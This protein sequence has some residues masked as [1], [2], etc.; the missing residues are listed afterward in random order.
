M[1]QPPERGARKPIRTGGTGWRGVQ[2][3]LLV[4]GLLPPLAMRGNS[5][6]TADP[7]YL[8]RA[9]ET[10][11]GLPEN[12]ATAMAQTT[13]GYLWFGTFEGLVRFDGVRFA[14]F[15]PANL[16]ELPSAA[17]VNLHGDALGRLWVSTD[18]GLCRWS[19]GRWHT[20]SEQDGWVGDYVRSF[21]SRSNG[22]VLL[23]TFDGH[24][25]EYANGRLRALPPPPGE[26]GRG[27]FTHADE[28]GRWWVIQHAFAG[29]WDGEAWKPAVRLETTIPDAV[30]AGGGHDGSLWIV[31]GPRLRHWRR[32]KEE[33]SVPLPEPP[34]GIW[35]VLGDRAG[36]VWICTYNRGLCRVG[37]DGKFR[38]WDGTRGGVEDSTRFVLEDGEDNLWV[39]TSGGGLVQF[40][41]RRFQAFGAGSGRGE[42]NVKAV[43]P[44][45]SGGMW[46]ATFGGGLVRWRPGWQEAVALSGSLSRTIY[47]QAVIEDR[48]GTTWFGALHRG[49]WQITEEGTRRLDPGET[50]GESIRALYEDGKG[51][52]WVGGDANLALFETGL[53]RPLPQAFKRPLPGVVAIAEEGDLQLWFSN[54]KAVFRLKSDEV[55]EVLGPT[56]APLADV[57]CFKPVGDGSVWMGTR[58]TGLWQWKAGNLARVDRAAGFPAAGAHAILEDDAGYFWMPS[59]QGVVRASRAVLAAA[60]EGGNLRGKVQLLDTGDGLPSLDMSSSSQPVAAPDA[61]GR[62][63]FATLKGMAMIEPRRFRP[64]TNPPPV[65]IEA[66]HY[67][68]PGKPSEA[69][70]G[71]SKP[72][73]DGT[74]E[75]EHGLASPFPARLRLPAGSRRLEIH[76]TATTFAA[77]EK[78]RFQVKLEKVDQ[79]WRDA[80]ARRQALFDDLASGDYVFRVRAAN[81]DGVWNERG[82]SLA[83]TVLPHYWET[84]WFRLGTGLFL[85]GWGAAAV[86]MAARRRLQRAEE[87]ERTA[88]QMRELA[89]RLINAQEDERRRIAREL[90]DDFSQRLALLSVEMDLC[91]AGLGQ[92]SPDSAARFEEMASRV[93]E[94]SS[95]VHR[96]AYELHPAKLDQLGL[97]AAARGFCRDLSQQTGV[98]IRFEACPLPTQL[99]PRQ[100]LCLYR[101]IQESLWNVVRHSGAKDARVELTTDAGHVRLVVADSGAGFDPTRAEGGLGLA[102]MLERVRLVQGELAVESK[103]GGGTRILVRLPVPPAP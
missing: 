45:S 41:P 14:V 44:A 4:L 103:P 74:G 30:G 75:Q 52:V 48:S 78:A 96:L 102:S 19:E 35:S 83:F 73:A 93:K 54:L 91:R 77:P 81:H 51:R 55:T 43:W 3:C 67:R 62:L 94:L 50:G 66:L 88:H 90:H 40:R 64:N 26:M 18:R 82:A 56:G 36:N 6:A 38:R 1:L 31:D 21:A 68:V 8:I 100:A 80:G 92:S 34:G 63:W 99:P 42:R 46:L 25:L 69:L 65:H 32:G 2:V 87:R 23:A 79:D 76:Y 5:A 85:V 53:A 97:A 98:A 47:G 39:G 70:A 72:S 24:V 49:L 60:A 95:E 10:E 13:D 101:I 57:L 9:W 84:A 27:Y 61:E 22:D 16:P 28:D 58:H 29:Y 37:A 15:T 59:R 86:W 20:F 12:S 17:I 33:A 71:P 7:E 89:G 11:D